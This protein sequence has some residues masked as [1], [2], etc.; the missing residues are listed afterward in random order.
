VEYIY[1]HVS[2]AGQGN[3]N[4]GVDQGVV[5]VTVSLHR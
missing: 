2:N 4:P 5:R 3:Q 1:R